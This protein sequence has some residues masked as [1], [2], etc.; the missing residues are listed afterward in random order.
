MSE[1]LKAIMELVSENTK[2]KLAFKKLR[3]VINEKKEK[4]DCVILCEEELEEIFYIA[5]FK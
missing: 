3:D 1:E 4:H 5:D 2:F